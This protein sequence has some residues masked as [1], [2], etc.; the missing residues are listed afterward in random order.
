MVSIRL[1][2]SSIQSH[3]ETTINPILYSPYPRI[4]AQRIKKP[5][6]NYSL[7]IHQP[8]TRKMTRIDRPSIQSNHFLRRKKKPLTPSPRIIEKRNQATTRN[9]SIRSSL[10]SVCSP[11][12]WRREDTSSSSRSRSPGVQLARKQTRFKPP[13]YD[14]SSRTSIRPFSMHE[15]KLR[16]FP[17]LSPSRRY[18]PRFVYGRRGPVP[19]RC[20]GNLQCGGRL[21]GPVKNE[22]RV[23][24]KRR[25]FPRYISKM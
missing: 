1:S 9:P 17:P 12:P 25:N 10:F 7:S 3:L 5:K 20:L 15:A 19:L 21:P 11:P 4:I 14:G 6:L 18:Q 24:T 2:I 22:R 16:R 8:W 13:F 23:E